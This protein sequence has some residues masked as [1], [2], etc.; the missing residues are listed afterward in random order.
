MHADRQAR[1]APVERK[2]HRGLPRE[3]RDRRERR[4][5]GVPEE[6]LDRP[7]GFLLPADRYWWKRE[8][9]REDDIDVAPERDDPPR[10]QLERAR[11]QILFDMPSA[12]RTTS[13]VERQMRE[14]NRRVNVGVRWSVRGVENLMRLS[15]THRHNPD[16]YHRLWS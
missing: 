2:G 8:R 12:E 4:E 6:L 10:K 7:V 5:L 11:S 13:L 14:I 3:V 16:D 15:M 1:V 9:G